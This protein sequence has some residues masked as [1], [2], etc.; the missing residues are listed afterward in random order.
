V[1]SYCD[2]CKN[3]LCN[4]ENCLN[5]FV[6]CL[7]LEYRQKLGSIMLLYAMHT[8]TLNIL[9]A[10]ILWLVSNGDIMA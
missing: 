9:F 4:L 10:E 8:C 5:L 1:S 7:V 2:M 6:R 3:V